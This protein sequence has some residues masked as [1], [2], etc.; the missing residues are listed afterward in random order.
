[1]ALDS[2][3]HAPGSGVMAVVG[4][5]Q[6]TANVPNLDGVETALFSYTLPANTLSHDGDSI[7]FE[8]YGDFSGVNDTNLFLKMGSQSIFDSGVIDP[9][10]TSWVLFGRIIRTGVAT[11]K[12]F[13][14]LVANALSPITLLGELTIDLSVANDLIVSGLAT[15]AASIEAEGAYLT[16]YSVAP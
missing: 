6:S 7:F 12:S 13:A 15:G 8:I 14:T 11:Q 10:A 1:M 4:L 5:S 2:A 9:P 3:L 16:L